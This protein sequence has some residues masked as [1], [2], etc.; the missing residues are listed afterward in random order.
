MAVENNE[1]FL[2]GLLCPCRVK[3]KLCL[4]LNFSLRHGKNILL[5]T[6][7]MNDSVHYPSTISSRA[8]DVA[9]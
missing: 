4:F 7:Q 9:L 1:S 3:A 5:V 8:G 6:P 2:H